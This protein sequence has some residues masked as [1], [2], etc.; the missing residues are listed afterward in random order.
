[1]GMT[2][3]NNS[4]WSGEYMDWADQERLIRQ[5]LEEI[6]RDLRRRNT[7]NYRIAE[8]EEEGYEHL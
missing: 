7:E 4:D 3:R 1:M 2:K 5:D 8:F 6:N